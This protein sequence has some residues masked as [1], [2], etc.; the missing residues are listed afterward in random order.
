MNL[1]KTKGFTL[2]ELMITVAIIGV[3]S[4]IALPSYQNYVA[5]SNVAAAIADLN[6]EKTRI[7]MAINEA[8]E[9]VYDGSYTVSYD[10]TG[11]CSSVEILEANLGGNT[12][13]LQ[14]TLKG[15]SS[16]NE[17]VIQFKRDKDTGEWDCASDVDEKFLPKS[18]TNIVH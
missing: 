4:A 14:C 13:T 2:I 3:L 17:K 7:E 5:K 9:L 16:I 6:P 18:C 15:V 8:K 10:Q 1:K 11:N 12:V